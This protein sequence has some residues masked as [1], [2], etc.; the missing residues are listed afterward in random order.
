MTNTVEPRALRFSDD[1]MIPNNPKLPMLVYAQ[2][3]DLDS[4][5]DPA[6]VFE[7]TFKRN[8]WGNSW[9]NG[10]FPYVHYHSAIH[11]VLG[12]A[13]GHARVRFG[14]NQGVELN[15]KAGDVAVLPAG[16]GHHRLSA[17]P[18][19]LVVGAYPPDGEYDLCRGS[20]EEL[21]AARISI[22]RVPIP[23]Y[24][25]LGGKGG[26]LPRLWRA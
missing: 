9:R 20:A 17:S 19:L 16:T 13:Q 6:A 26:A 7:Q 3:F 2:A 12:I 21:R 23:D 22:P 15:L 11:E 25:P 5:P 4:E 14:G 8:R 24:D 18:D 10:I 1:G